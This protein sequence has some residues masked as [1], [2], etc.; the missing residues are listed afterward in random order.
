MNRYTKEY[1]RKLA[2][3]YVRFVDYTAECRVCGSACE[4][5]YRLAV[6][7]RYQFKVISGD[8]HPGTGHGGGGGNND[9]I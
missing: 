4:M 7:K 5:C 3:R 1:A 8:N 6:A 9:P 2:L